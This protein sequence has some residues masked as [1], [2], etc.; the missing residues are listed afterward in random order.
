[1]SPRAFTIN[2][3]GTVVWEELSKNNEDKAN[4]EI[5]RS[6]PK[7]KQRNSTASAN[8]Q[9]ETYNYPF[10]KW[11]PK[12]ISSIPGAIVQL[13]TTYELGTLKYKLSLFKPSSTQPTVMKP[14]VKQSQQGIQELANNANQGL[15][16]S[17]I[18]YSIDIQLL[19]ANGFKLTGFSIQQRSWDVVPGTTVFEAREQ[20]GCQE[21]DYKRS[22]DYTVK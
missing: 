11:K 18:P 3:L 21:W 14:S 5:Q 13:S 6:K 19:D 16:L 9:Y 12:P 2:S 20:I 17:T 10:I 8:D 22:C 4:A 15:Q 1:S 7:P